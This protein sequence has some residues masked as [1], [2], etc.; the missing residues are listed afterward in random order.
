M[1]AQE[2]RELDDWIAENVFGSHRHQDKPYRDPR[3]RNLPIRQE[4][5]HK[6]KL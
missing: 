4:A 3:T 2:M 5:I 6:I 1:N